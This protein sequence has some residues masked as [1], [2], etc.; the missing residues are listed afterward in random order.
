MEKIKISRY[1]SPVGELMLGS[2]GDELCMCDWVS[3]KQPLASCQRICRHLGGECEEGSSE[4]IELAADQ[5]D[6]YFRGQRSGFSVPVKFAG[7]RFQKMV[8]SGLLKI[9]YGT[10]VSYAE[11]A[12]SINCPNGV[13]AVASAIGR[14]PISIIVPCHRVIGSNRKFTGYAGGLAAKQHLLALEQVS[15]TE[16][17]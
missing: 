9:P 17:L 12:G 13:R 3:E 14:N 1:S 5:L 11:L 6:E 8:W 2:W 10:T 7:T 15:S 4:V 16:I